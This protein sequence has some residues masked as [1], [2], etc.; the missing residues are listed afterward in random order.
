MATCHAGK[1]LREVNGDWKTRAG[2]KSQASP[3]SPF[4]ACASIC[5]LRRKW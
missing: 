5:E 4:A 1:N 3:S 2:S